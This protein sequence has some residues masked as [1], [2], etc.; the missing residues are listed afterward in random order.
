M[1]AL[2]A[3]QSATPPN[4]VD[5][6]SSGTDEGRHRDENDYIRTV[7]VTSEKH[8][9]FGQVSVCLICGSVGKDAEG[10]MISCATCAQSYHTFCVGLHDKVC[11]L[12]LNM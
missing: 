9:Y 7:V 1:A 12:L 11:A 6:E 8:S 5:Q 3:A 2:S 4:D 10:T